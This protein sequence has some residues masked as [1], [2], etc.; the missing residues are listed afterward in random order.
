M[1]LIDCELKGIEFESVEA[2][3]LIEVFYVL[4]KANLIVC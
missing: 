1:A 3:L 4:V 2:I